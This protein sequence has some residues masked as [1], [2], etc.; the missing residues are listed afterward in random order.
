LEFGDLINSTKGL[1]EEKIENWGQFD[2]TL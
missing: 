2:K 1:I